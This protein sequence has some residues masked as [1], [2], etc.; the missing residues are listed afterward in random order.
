M[1]LEEAVRKT[2][3]DDTGVSGLVQSRI[4]PDIAIENTTFP[5]VVYSRPDSLPD[6]ASYTLEGPGLFRTTIVL[7]ALGRTSS[8]AHAVAD[9]IY[10]AL[11]P[12]QAQQSLQGV[13]PIEALH[14]SNLQDIGRDEDSGIYRFDRTM[15]ILQT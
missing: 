5:C 13:V 3:M 14:F 11:G 1:T 10:G 7:S 15:E 9:A 8:E 2:L 12:F 6:E 4:Y